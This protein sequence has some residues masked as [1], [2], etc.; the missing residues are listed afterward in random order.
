M[1][2]S[3]VLDITCTRMLPTFRC[4]HLN[5]MENTTKKRKNKTREVRSHGRSC[6]LLR[7]CIRDCDRKKRQ[8]GREDDFTSQ[9]LHIRPSDVPRRP[10]VGTSPPSAGSPCSAPR[11]RE[12]SS[13]CL[14]WVP[15]SA[16]LRPPGKSGTCFQFW[17]LVLLS[18]IVYTS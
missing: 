4:F 1:E 13:T 17:S 7:R 6:K 2:I 12:T 11:V 3:I 8:A 10:A 9:C 18:S 14:L 16:S 15:L 5:W